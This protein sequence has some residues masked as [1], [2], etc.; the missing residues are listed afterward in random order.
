MTDSIYWG[1]KGIFSPMLYSCLIDNLFIGIYKNQF[2]RFDFTLIRVYLSRIS[3]FTT[4]NIYKDYF[5]GRHRW[6]K[7]M[8]LNVKVFQFIHM[9]KIKKLLGY[10]TLW[11]TNTTA[12]SRER[13]TRAYVSGHNML[14]TT[15]ATT[16]ASTCIK[17][18]DP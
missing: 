16:F 12:S 4:L 13:W 10:K 9:M 11:H 2:F 7:L 15:S 18:H 5:K 3:F 14:A 8:Q 1:L 17:W 6:C